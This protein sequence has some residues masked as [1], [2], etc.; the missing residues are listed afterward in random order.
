MTGRFGMT[1]TYRNNKAREHE[2]LNEGGVCIWGGDRCLFMDTTSV[3]IFSRLELPYCVGRVMSKENEKE[4][5]LTICSVD[6]TRFAL[7]LSS[8]TSAIA[9]YKRCV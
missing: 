6:K 9:S 8:C 1:K 4:D 2:V 5:D 3:S 7:S